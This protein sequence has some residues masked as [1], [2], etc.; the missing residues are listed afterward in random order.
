MGLKKQ[1]RKISILKK[2]KWPSYKQ[3]SRVFKILTRK[4][5]KAF[6]IF[7][8]SAVISGILLFSLLYYNNTHIIPALGGEYKEGLIG[9]PRLINPIYASVSDVDRDLVEILFSGLLRYNQSG[10]IVPGLAKEVQITGEG[11]IYE[12]ILRENA[13]WHDQAPITADD[14]VFTIKTIQN[15]EYKSPLRAAWLGV[16]VEKISNH[17][18]RFELDNSYSPFL[19]NLC[20]KILP[21]H[22]WQNVPAQSFALTS[23]NLEPVGSGPYKIKSISQNKSGKVKS[24]DLVRFK[25]YWGEAPKI[26]KITFYFF[27][28]EEDLIKAAKKNDIQ[29]ISLVSTDGY[30]VFKKQELNLYTPSLP[31]YFAVFF[32]SNK[33]EVL[34]EKT[35]RQALTYAVNKEE[36]IKTLLKSEAKP[37]DSPILPKIYGFDEPETIYEFN[38]EKAKEILESSGFVEKENGLREK[39]IKKA[40]GDFKSDLKKGS[41]GAE[42]KSLQQCL[43]QDPEVYP[44]GTVS[45]YF[46]NKTK[47]AVIK[48]Q[49]KYADDIL[50][51]WGFTTGTGLVSETTREKLNELCGEE[52]PETL[53]LK[54]TLVTVNQSQM[55]KTAELLKEQWKTVG[56]EVKIKAIKPFELE[57]EFIKPRNYEALLFGEVLGI[58]PD[59]FPF[60]HSS[61][62]KD[63]GLNLS[64]YENKE[65]D[66][67]L[68]QARQ[69]M[70]PNEKTEKLVLF[71]NLLI[72][73]LPAIFLYTP[74]Y[75]YWVSNKIKGIELELIADPSKR[76]REIEKWYIE[77]RRAWKP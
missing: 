65:A 37:V 69:T 16:R 29:G 38:L 63:P 72:E 25:K 68:E 21:K 77:T 55:V 22:I 9:Q 49:E 6:F 18:V 70:E 74:N 47:T 36:L 13:L 39:P 7:L 23:F 19:E 26:K 28:Q 32:N 75:L 45:G 66:K 54:F 50:K 51:P 62:K 8:I 52:S 24:L 30:D 41:Q 27:E 4:E 10:E 43:A 48:F 40:D 34:K 76:F 2:N 71:Q 14:V 3:W 5:K 60:W 59:P 33:S 35:I 31:R 17:K 44:D 42:V 53:A 1:R 57:Q 12:L 61:Q 11:Q 46:G 56:A 73:D 64:Q 67:L 20:L 58:I 15:P